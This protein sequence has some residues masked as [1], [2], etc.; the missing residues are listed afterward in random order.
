MKSIESFVQSSVSSFLLSFFS[1]P[2]IAIVYLLAFLIICGKYTWIWFIGFQISRSRIKREIDFFLCW[3]LKTIDKD[4][5]RDREREKIVFHYARCGWMSRKG[6]ESL[7]CHSP[8]HER[9]FI[10]FAG[11]N[12]CWTMKTFIFLLPLKI[13]FFVFHKFFF[14]C[15]SLN[16]SLYNLIVLFWYFDVFIPFAFVI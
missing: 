15:G 11:V 14:L 16:Y 3:L 7:I 6:V 1:V 5:E 8:C 9:L 4:R 2:S 10:L 12:E 13:N